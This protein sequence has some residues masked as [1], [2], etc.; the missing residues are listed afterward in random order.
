M[1]AQLTS[2]SIRSQRPDRRHRGVVGDI[3][4]DR[5]DQWVRRESRD[6]VGADPA[7]DDPPAGVRKQA[8]NPLADAARAAETATVARREGAV[9]LAVGVRTCFLAGVA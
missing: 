3:E 7:G 4:S 2:A 9:R 1:P 8:G 5:F 6:L